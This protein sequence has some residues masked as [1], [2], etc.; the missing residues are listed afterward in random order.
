MSFL[1]KIFNPQ[2]FNKIIALDDISGEMRYSKATIEKVAHIQQNILNALGTDVEFKVTS[3]YISP[4]V[5]PLFWSLPYV[6]NI[7]DKRVSISYDNSNTR[8]HDAVVRHGVDS[9]YTNKDC[10][11]D[12]TKVPFQLIRNKNNTITELETKSIVEKITKILP[13]TMASDYEAIF[14]SKLYEVFDNSIKHGSNDIGL[15]ANGYFDKNKN[16]FTF[17]VYDFGIGIPNNVRKFTKDEFL[18]DSSCIQWALKDG[19]TTAMNDY[20]RGAGFGVLEKFVIENKGKIVICSGRCYC[21]ITA[22]G[23]KF[24]ELKTDVIGTF[25]SMRINADKRHIYESQ[26][27]VT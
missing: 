18:T 17:T 5:Y 6:G 15:F 11:A 25:F 23:R 12:D 1:D 13:I 10:S 16:K 4:G 2:K 26:E 14:V 27:E 21:E 19:N 9:H 3:P 24:S 20:S 8:L 7:C 22:Y